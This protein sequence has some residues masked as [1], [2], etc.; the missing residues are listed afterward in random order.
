MAVE[1]PFELLELYDG[2][3]F[4]LQVVRWEEGRTTIFPPFAPGGK[5]IPVLRVH[6]NPEA[7]PTGLDYWDI[8]SKTLIAQLRPLLQLAHYRQLE[9]TIRAYGE[10]PKKRFTV[11][12]HSKVVR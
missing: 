10:K 1:E 9:F 11:E 2:Q 7:Q 4:S 5:E 8:T 6:V 3:V 12:T